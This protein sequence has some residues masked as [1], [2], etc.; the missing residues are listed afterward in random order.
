MGGDRADTS[1][2]TADASSSSPAS[3]S[4][5][6]SSSS[7]R[8]NVLAAARRALTGPSGPALWLGAA[9]AALLTLGG[10]GAGSLPVDGGPAAAVGLLGFTFG[11]GGILALILCWVGI[12]L[13]ATSWLALGPRAVSGRLPTRDA[14]WAT[15]LWSLPLLPSVPLF[16]TDAWTYLSQGAMANA[17]ISPYDHGAVAN[18][19][20]FT[21]EVW[22]D[23]R[24]TT[25]PYGPLHILLMQVVVALSGQSPTT[26]IVL[27]RVA[28]L[29]ALA[30]LVALVIVAARRTGTDP[31]AAV[32]MA[33]ASPLTVVHL[34][35]G[36]HNEI[37]PLLACVAAVV[38]AMH[39]RAL[40]AGAAMGLAVAVKVNAVLIAPFLVW[41]VLARRRTGPGVPRPVTR[42]FADTALAA[43]AAGVV[44]TLITSISGLGTGWL[45]ALSVSDRVINYLSLPTAVAHLVHPF[46]DAGLEDVLAVS[47]DVGMGL[48]I[49]ILVAVWATHRRDERAALRGILLA[50]LAFVLLN[51][52]SWPWYHVWLA[53]F[54]VVARPGRRATTLA[55]GATVFLLLVIGPDGSTSLYS[56]VLAAVAVLAAVGT[57][58]WWRRA[59]G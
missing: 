7:V 17:G 42:T 2:S 22:Q 31:G 29:L 32:W 48:L 41:I 5:A 55:V 27:L 44:F 12:A 35:G 40:G 13:M 59:T 51:T 45:G 56:P 37:F 26:G 20:P 11:H 18:P 3:S 4:P 21:D 36:L 23:W 25:A 49:V 50:L 8:A 10:F 33:C 14:V 34:V 52:L 47:R 16:S 39:A 9:G 57:I 38:L 46:V 58:A 1:G 54:W 43:G 6:S 28:V 53:A 19:G 30:G 15:V 24:T